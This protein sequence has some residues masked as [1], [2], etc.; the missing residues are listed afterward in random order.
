[1]LF[2]REVDNIP[3]KQQIIISGNLKLNRKLCNAG[4]KQHFSETK[5]KSNGELH[6]HFCLNN[7]I[8]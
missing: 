8:I 3:P 6:L 2:Q 1:M 4:I 7:K 5:C